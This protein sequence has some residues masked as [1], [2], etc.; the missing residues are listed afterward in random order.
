MKVGK[1][2]EKTSTQRRKKTVKDF[3]D[4]KIKIIF[5]YGVLSTGFDAPSTEAILIAR[6][7]TSPVIYSQMLGRGLRGPKFGGKSECILIDIK[8][9]LIGLPDEKDCFSLFNKYYK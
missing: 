6:P 3:R 4:G 5:N 2:D 8:D 9:N 1:I 7:T